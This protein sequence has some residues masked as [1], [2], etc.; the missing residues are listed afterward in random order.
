MYIHCWLNYL[1]LYHDVSVRTKRKKKTTM[2][3]TTS[4]PMRSPQ[5][6]PKVLTLIH[7]CFSSDRIILNVCMHTCMYVGIDRQPHSPVSGGG[8]GGSNQEEKDVSDDHDPAAITA[9][10]TQEEN[11]LK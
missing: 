1:I 9:A 8:V 6:Y 4:I 10:D 3:T 2:M 5:M 11:E 7:D